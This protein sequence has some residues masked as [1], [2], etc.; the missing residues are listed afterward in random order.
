MKT[1]F[2]NLEAI[3][4]AI[5][6]IVVLIWSLR[7]KQAPSPTEQEDPKALLVC[8][9]CHGTGKAHGPMAKDIYASQVFGSSCSL[10]SGNGKVSK[11][12]YDFWCS[13]NPS[14]HP[15][16]DHSTPTRNLS[17]KIE[18]PDCYG[19]G[20]CNMC[21][22]RGQ[23]EHYDSYT[24]TYKYSD[25]SNCNGRGICPMCHGRKYL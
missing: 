17:D 21:A 20:K 7:D 13:Q 15:K 24:L 5:L 8:P 16:S 10:C 25:C 1:K 6:F 22:G 3:L 2:F 14:S 18:C 19:S 9:N 23:R 4:I 12:V 11:E